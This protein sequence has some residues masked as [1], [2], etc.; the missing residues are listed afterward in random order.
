MLQ[1]RGATDVSGTSRF[2][3]H[4][5]GQERAGYAIAPNPANLAP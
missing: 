2:A 1:A 4:N 5:W 3:L